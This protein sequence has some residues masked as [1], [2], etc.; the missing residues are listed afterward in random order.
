MFSIFFLNRISYIIN[1]GIIQKIELQE[2][3]RKVREKNH[4]I[5]SNHNH[6]NHDEIIHINHIHHITKITLKHLKIIFLLHL[7]GMFL[8]F[9]CFIIEYFG[10]NIFYY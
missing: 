3:T 8:S 5:Q 9:C 1:S 6:H 2:F 7:F 4:Q 10:R